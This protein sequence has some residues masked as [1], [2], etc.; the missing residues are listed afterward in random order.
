MKAT[1][2]SI[3][4]EKIG[5]TL[6]ENPICA[7]LGPRQCGKTTLARQIQQKQQGHFFD[8]ESEKDRARLAEPELALSRLKGLVILDEIQ[9]MPALF[10]V[11]RVLADD[12]SEK[13]RRFL[14]LG[15]ASPQLVRG[16]SES[17]A[18]RVG[19]VDLSGFSL[20]EIDPL[21]WRKLWIR[22]A[23]PRSYLAKT[24]PASQRWREAFIRT[25]L[26]KDIP[27]LGI[28]IPAETLRRFWMMIAHSH[29][30][31]WNGADLARSMGISE[32]T[33]RHYLHILAGTYMLR[34]LPPWF[35]NIGKRQYKSSKIYIR[36]SGIFHSLLAL[37]DM[38][39]LE[40]HP[41]YGA[42][43]EGFAL[44]QVLSVVGAQNAYF[45]GTHAGAEL[46]LMLIR[47]GKHF[48]IEFKCSASPKMTK[49]L[50]IAI[51]NLSLEKAWI[52]YPGEHIFPVHEKVD[53][54]PISKLATLLT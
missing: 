29:S 23:F 45:W 36:D 47:N 50:R 44:E 4:L 24:D 34:I 7:L 37:N 53:A 41:Q 25:F 48:G 18:G 42:S 49:S 20:H 38:S 14:I 30:K 35:V 19:F 43:W 54:L 52:I 26:E 46:D 31:I 27:Q 16:V 10:E 15:S 5:Q 1:E 22:G 32:H 28:R 8:L 9:R 17:L 3:Y 13:S 2:R 51:D 39:T 11:L 40:S 6:A 33:V 21:H 12:D